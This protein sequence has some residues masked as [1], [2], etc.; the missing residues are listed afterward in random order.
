[1]K[2]FLLAVCGLSPQVITETLYALHQQGEQIDGIRV[3]TTRGGKDACLVSLFRAGDGMFHR[4]L[5]EFG[6]LPTAI[7]FTPRHVVAVTGEDGIEIDDIASEADN[8]CFL[9]ACME[10]AFELT[11]DSDVRVLF[12]IAGGRKT[13][14]ACLSIAAQCY[15][16]PQDRIYHVLVSPEF[17]GCRDFFYPPQPPREVEVRTREGKP[18]LMCTAQAEISLIPMPFFPLRRHLSSALLKGPESP[19]TLMMSLVREVPPELIINLWEGKLVWK[20]EE[21]DMDA[22]RLSIYALFAEAK[23]EGDCR[24]RSCQRCSECFLTFGMVGER[25]EKL[26]EIYRRM[27][28]REVSGGIAALEVGDF[29]SYRSKLNRDIKNRFGEYEA[30]KIALKASGQRPNTRYGI[31]LAKS[32]VR[33]VY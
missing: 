22:A 14:G 15:G 19:S 1:M 12:S 21:L 18:C 23:K 8:E 7:D 17:E 5:D 4:Y 10:E 25:N 3:L 32:Q 20:G 27:T 6:L 11:R 33:I 24:R 2:T 16:R 30:G 28:T 9:R 31:P 13:M 26:L 29:N